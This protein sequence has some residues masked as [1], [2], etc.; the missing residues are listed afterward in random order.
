MITLITLSNSYIFTKSAV[1]MHMKNDNKVMTMLQIAA[2]YGDTD[3]CRELGKAYHDGDAVRIDHIK[4]VRYLTKASEEGDADAQYVLGMMY[5]N[6]TMVRIDLPAAYTLL[7]RSS[8]SGN[9]AAL[10]QLGMMYLNGIYVRRSEMSAY[11]CF[12][13]CSEMGMREA[14]EIISDFTLLSHPSRRA[15]TPR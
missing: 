10:Y 5:M 2:D 14:D 12:R 8:I 15:C 11:Q 3:A 4:A 6:G 13:R 7:R 1:W 9:T